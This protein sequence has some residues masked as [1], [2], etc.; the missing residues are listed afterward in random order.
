MAVHSASGPGGGRG[1]AAGGPANR[2]TGRC[3]TEHASSKRKVWMYTDEMQWRFRTNTQGRYS[4]VEEGRDDEHI[5]PEAM[6]AMMTRTLFY[7]PGIADEPRER[8][9]RRQLSQPLNSSLLECTDLPS[10]KHRGDGSVTLAYVTSR[11]VQA[12]TS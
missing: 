12:H 8:R 9:V 2:S 1:A 6:I 5:I 11:R 3:T 7:A 10:F 4:R